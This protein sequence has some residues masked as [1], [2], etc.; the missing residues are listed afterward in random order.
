MAF[1]P[2]EIEVDW[3]IFLEFFK[4]IGS[5][6]PIV[7][8]MFVILISKFQDPIK[9]WIKN[10]RVKYGDAELSS[11]ASR[12]DEESEVEIKGVKVDQSAP[13]DSQNTSE[14]AVAQW[15]AAAY[16]WEY[17][18]LN[19]HLVLHTQ[20][21]LDWVSGLKKPVAIGVADALWTL[22]IQDPKERKAVVDALEQHHLV[23]VDR[24]TIAI[25][26]KGKEYIQLRGEVPP[27]FPELDAIAKKIEKDS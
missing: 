15:R 23:V 24:G 2:W 22:K 26:E 13:A 3:A 25:T 12:R 20:Q 21:F 16:L 1:I 4:V 10:L 7:L 14:D 8:I 11:Q 5:W 17:R 19:R 18:Y 9:S 27:A 6:P